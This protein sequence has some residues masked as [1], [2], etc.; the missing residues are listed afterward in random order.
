MSL[1]IRSC[2]TLLA[3]TAAN[4]QPQENK[5][6]ASM[7]TWDTSHKVGFVWRRNPG[8]QEDFINSKVIKISN[9]LI[10]ILCLVSAC[11]WQCIYLFFCEKFYIKYL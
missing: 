3:R 9:P 4:T 8:V 2:K 11:I 1:G 10:T 6:K 5:Q 7:I